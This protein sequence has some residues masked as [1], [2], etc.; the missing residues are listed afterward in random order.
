MLMFNSVTAAIIHYTINFNKFLKNL[1]CDLLHITILETSY[2]F[3]II[4]LLFFFSFFSSSLNSFIK[5]KIIIN[6]IDSAHVAHTT[7]S[8][9]PSIECTSVSASTTLTMSQH[10]LL[11]LPLLLLLLLD[12]SARRCSRHQ[13]KKL[14]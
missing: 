13:K 14:S 1:N 2:I 8:I 5:K 7:N 9:C 11:C 3:T 6:K 12:D 4:S 10:I